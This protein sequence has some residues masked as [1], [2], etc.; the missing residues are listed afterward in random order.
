[1]IIHCT[2]EWPLKGIGFDRESTSG[3]LNHLPDL[4]S[5][6]FY[7][8]KEELRSSGETFLTTKGSFD[9]I[10]VLEGFTKGP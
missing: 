8:D 5:R 3:S 10:G 7:N 9:L 2:L 6:T 4:Y 1:M